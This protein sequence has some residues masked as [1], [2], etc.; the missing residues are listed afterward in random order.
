MSTPQPKTL[1]GAEWFIFVLLLVSYAYFLPRWADWNVNSRMDSILAVVDRQTFA[2]DAYYQNTGDYA[3]YNGHFYSDKAPGTMFVG[4]PIY[5]LYKGLGGNALMELLGERFSNSAFGSTLTSNG[6]GMTTDSLKFFGALVFV[7]FWASVVPAA[8]LGVVLY[9]FALTWAASPWY[10]MMVALAYGL[11]TPAFA[12]ANN[13]YGHT[14]SAFYLFTAFYLARRAT[15]TQH[16]V[17]YAGATGF[18]L[19]MALLTE[20]PTALI[21]AAIG[22]YALYKWRSSKLVLVA[23]AA[24]ALLLLLLGLYN[25]VI[26]QTPLPVGYLYSPLYEHEHHIGLLSLTYPKIETL[27]ELTFGL[28]RGLFLIS[29]YLILALVG[30]IWFARERAARPEF[31]VTVLAIVSFFLFNASSAMWLG[32]FGIGP[33]YLLPMLPFLALPFVFTLNHARALWQRAVIAVTLLISLASVWFLTLGG[34]MFPQ[35][36]AFPLLEYTLPRWQQGDI[37]RNLGMILNFKNY[38][39]LLPLL[40]MLMIVV[41]LY[42]W[43]VQHSSTQ[44]RTASGKT[45]LVT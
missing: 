19:G 13:L 20:Y 38:N 21:V 24:G 4:I 8:G 11:A 30:L 43:F 12:Y 45:R 22:L 10:A 6:R 31:L 39:S 3:F 40:F 32:G 36:Q 2:I 35:Y 14:L 44:E 27:W 41:G 29:P 25:F 18:L 7:T 9:R 33:R 23:C 26:F 28:Q 5:A 17:L 42:I 34:Q 16:S 37:A 1:R 15:D